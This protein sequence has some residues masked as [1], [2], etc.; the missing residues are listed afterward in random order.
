[1][2]IFRDLVTFIGMK[3]Q[4]FLLLGVTANE[5]VI[6]GH[7]TPIPGSYQQI[8]TGAL[9]SAVG[10]VIPTVTVPTNP[11]GQVV[12]VTPGYMIVQNSGSVPVR[13]RD[14]GVAPTAS[15]G[16]VL[17]AGTELDYVGDFSGIKFIQTGAGAQLEITLYF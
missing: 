4:R 7:R 17:A 1:M 12:Q 8:L 9:G 11:G 6:T 10:I 15:V 13:W 14:D 16:M 5:A 3:M 2:R